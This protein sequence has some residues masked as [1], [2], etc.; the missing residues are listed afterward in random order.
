MQ[1]GANLSQ[2]AAHRQQA[3][4]E[5]TTEDKNKP[6]CKN[7]MFEKRLQNRCRFAGPNLQVQN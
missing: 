2:V 6:A 7:K 5:D 4:N 3:S 1:I